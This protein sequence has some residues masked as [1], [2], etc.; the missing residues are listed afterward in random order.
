[1]EAEAVDEI[2]ASTSLTQMLLVA[3]GV[4]A[5]IDK[6]V[7][8]GFKDYGVRGGMQA[9]PQNFRFGENLGIIP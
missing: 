3:S 6:E 7:G 9:H 8:S 4:D 2:A 5:I 1:V